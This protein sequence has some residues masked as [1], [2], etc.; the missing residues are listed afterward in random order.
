MTP[1]GPDVHT[2]APGSASGFLR[3]VRSSWSFY[4]VTP[5]HSFRGASFGSLWGNSSHPLLSQDGNK[6]LATAERNG[7]DQ[8]ALTASYAESASAFGAS[9]PRS[10]IFRAG[11]PT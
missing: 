7:W 3:A 9:A 8:S 11:E 4:R 5:S 10:R 6:T 1:N 2:S